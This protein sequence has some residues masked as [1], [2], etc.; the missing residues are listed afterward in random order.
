MEGLYREK[1][2]TQ[3]EFNCVSVAL[4]TEDIDRLEAA[5]RAGNLPPTS[6]FFFGESDG[7][8][9]DDDLA[10]VAKAREA[11]NGGASILLYLMVVIACGSGTEYRF[12]SVL[13]IAVRPTTEM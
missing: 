11:I 7:T 2:G 3:P 6:G 12:R 9:R 4:A 5:L 8:E 1:G 10:F 13:M